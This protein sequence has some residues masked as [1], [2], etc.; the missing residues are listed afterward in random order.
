[1]ESIK[2]HQFLS[3]FAIFPLKKIITQR[4]ASQARVHKRWHLIR[5][6]NFESQ[7]QKWLVMHKH[8]NQWRWF[9]CKQR[10]NSFGCNLQLTWILGP[11]DVLNFIIFTKFSN[12]N[13]FKQYE[14]LSGIKPKWPF[15]WTQ[16][17]NLKAICSTKVVWQV[18]HWC[19]HKDNPSKTIILLI[20]AITL[21]SVFAK[22]PSVRDSKNLSFRWKF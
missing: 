20:T 18:Y 22:F 6:I 15:N 17:H 11:K 10:L 3:I 16:R 1:M 19:C 12:G 21:V 14:S 5:D 13:V 2:A 9:Q 8:V 7:P 4:I